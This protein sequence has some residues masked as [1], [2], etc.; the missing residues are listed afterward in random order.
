MPIVTDT[1][2]TDLLASCRDALCPGYV[3]VPMR[4]IERETAFTYGELS[5][6]GSQTPHE[7]MIAHLPERS[8]TQYVWLS[9]EDEPCPVCGGPRILDPNKR[10]EYETKSGQDPLELVKRE[11]G[12]NREQDDRESALTMQREMLE[13]KRRELDLRERELAA[14]VKREPKVK[15]PAA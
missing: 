1:D 5:G 8:T 12:L 10:P 15:A 4:G 7:Q 11:R 9:Q 3:Q 13:L 14:Q 6:S 2:R